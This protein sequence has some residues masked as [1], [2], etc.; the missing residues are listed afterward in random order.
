M[1]GESK[2]RS[3]LSELKRPLLAHSVPVSGDLEDHLLGRGGA[4]P[5]PDPASLPGASRKAKVPTV[6]VTFHLPLE[7]RDRLKVTAQAHQRTMLDI[8]VEALNDYL[9]RNPVTERD[10]RRLLGL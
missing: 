6:P 9:S 10:L 5:A 1:S 8:A 7:L 3:V 4:V 2:P